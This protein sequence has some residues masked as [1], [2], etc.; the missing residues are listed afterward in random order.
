MSRPHFGIVE[1][2]RIGQLPRV[3]RNMLMERGMSRAT[4]LR[5]LGYWKAA[6]GV[7]GEVAE[8]PLLTVFE[9]AWTKFRLSKRTDL[10]E[11]RNRIRD[12]VDLTYETVEKISRTKEVFII[13]TARVDTMRQQVLSRHVIPIPVIKSEDPVKAYKIW[14]ATNEL[15]EKVIRAK[16]VELNLEFRNKQVEQARLREKIAAD[17]LNEKSAK[18]IE[19]EHD[20]SFRLKEVEIAKEK[21]RMLE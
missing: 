18:S 12:I 20:L 14:I 17:D 2:M 15:K 1:A 3:T 13:G 19:V 10:F 6:R 8:K 5:W 16:E 7:Q 9:E 4:A 11:L 21:L